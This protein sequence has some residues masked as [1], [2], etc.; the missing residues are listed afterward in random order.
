MKIFTFASVFFLFLNVS[1]PVYALTP[2]MVEDGSL[3]KTSDSPDVYI[4]KF[5]N[6]KKFK[7]LILNPDI[8][9]SYGHL[10]W[11]NIRTVSQST[12]DEYTISELVLEV[13]PDGS[14]ADPKVYRVRSAANS[15]VGERRWMNMTAQEFETLGNDWDSIYHINHTEASPNFYPTGEPLVYT[16]TPNATPMIVKFTIEADDYGFYISGTDINSVSA[17]KGENVEITYN[18]KSTNVYYGGLDFRGCGENSA[19]I[20]PGGS[21]LVK[22]TAETSCD[23]K[24]YWPASGV[25]KDQMTVNV[26]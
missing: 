8:F 10:K 14:V 6:N 15:D 11:E 18:V 26:N 16:L 17:K 25:L 24:S 5:I 7:R 9:N 21:T 12:M 3:I 13:N 19:T 22:F 4:V 20:L 23:I 2:P 1:F